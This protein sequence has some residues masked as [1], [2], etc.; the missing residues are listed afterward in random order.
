MAVDLSQLRL[1]LIFLTAFSQYKIEV[2]ADVFPSNA[3]LLGFVQSHQDSRFEVKYHPPGSHIHREPDQEVVLMID[4]DKRKFE[5]VL[6]R[7]TEPQDYKDETLQQNTS[8]VSLMTDRRVTKTPDELL[9][10]LKDQCLR[11]DEGWWRYELCYHG[12]LR[13]MHIENG[14]LVQEFVLGTYDSD[15]TADF[16]KNLSDVSLQKDHRSKN[17]AQR[18]HSHIYSNGTLCDLTNEPR[19]TEVR[20][21][22]SDTGV[23]MISSIT[24]VATCKYMLILSTP[25]LC[26]F[27]KKDLSLKL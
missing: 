22:C 21:V 17:A 1:L 4:G 18:Y 23:N 27:N 8:S 2:E 10:V 13:Q 3:A 16:H 9:A 5:C 24:E 11:R 26:Y 25:I 12:K 6:P 19:E 15:A 7:E 20:F 14:K